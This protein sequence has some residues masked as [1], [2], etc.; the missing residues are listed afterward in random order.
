MPSNYRH[1]LH[2]GNFADV[3]KHWLLNLVLQQLLASPTPLHYLESHA[4]AGRYQRGGSFPSG[5]GRLWEQPLHGSSLIHYRSHVARLNPDGRLNI[6]PGSPL[7][8]AQNLR[9]QDRG[10]LVE[11]DAKTFAQL[12]ANLC[13]DNRIEL[14][15][16]DGLAL[17]NEQLLQDGH[18]LLLLDPPFTSTE[19]FTQ[20]A[21]W[22][23]QHRDCIARGHLILWFPITQHQPYRELLEVLPHTPDAPGLC[24]KFI[25]HRDSKGMQG[26]GLYLVNPPPDIAQRIQCEGAELAARLACEARLVKIPG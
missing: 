21:A 15:Q 18:W 19:E 24:S 25:R 14:K 8:A 5:I 7:I 3:H 16:G 13:S 2:A 10:T 20:V 6:Y 17:I 1:Q 22:L 23:S 26:S 9:T 12:S 4:G 11:L